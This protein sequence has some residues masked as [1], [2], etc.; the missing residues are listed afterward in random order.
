MEALQ[1]ES[2]GQKKLLLPGGSLGS[3]GNQAV[4]KNVI[5]HYDEQTFI[6]YSTVLCFPCLIL[7]NPPNSPVCKYETQVDT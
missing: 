2:T 6:K 7:F 3:R 5:E 4:R 1:V